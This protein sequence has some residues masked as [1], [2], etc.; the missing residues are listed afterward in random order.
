MRET[1]QLLTVCLGLFSCSIAEHVIATTP[2][3]AEER[4][5]AGHERFLRYC[6]PC[7]GREG[8]GN[9]PVAAS[10]RR[11]PTDLTDVALRRG[12][13]DADFVAQFIDGRIRVEEHGTS[14]MPV[15][16]RRFDDRNAEMAQEALLTRGAISLIVE[17]L[18]SVQV[19]PEPARPDSASDATRQTMDQIFAALAYLLPASVDDERF[20]GL[21]ERD[22]IAAG[23]QLLATSVNALEAHGG[24]RDPGFQ[25]LGG[26]LAEDTREIQ[27]R[28]SQQ[29][30]A[31]AQFFLQQLTE[32]CVA[33]HSRLP[34]QG[35]FAF[36]ESLLKQMDIDRMEAGDH[37]RLLV[38]VRQFEAALQ[39][40]EGLFADTKLSAAEI[41][42]SGYLLDYLTIC[43][44][45]QGDLERPRLAL[46]KFA[47]RPD[48]PRYLGHHLARWI[49]SLRELHAKP[50]QKPTLENARELVRQSQELLAA[51]AN[52]EGLVY[53]LMASSLLHRFVDGRSGPAEE[54]AEAF[55]LL[56]VIQ[57][58]IGY[59]PWVPETE[60]YLE[61]S[62]RLA[63]AT[64]SAER[65]YLLLEEYTVLGYGGSSGTYLP[66]DVVQ[67]LAELRGLLDAP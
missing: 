35:E 22:G 41:D 58:R 63:P 31:E 42:L 43:I 47:A 32:N 14:D 59:A 54:L 10:L 15:W 26:S 5:A 36:A 53:D 57:A 61:A 1:F 25:F 56:G 12:G 40:W 28:F 39:T 18:Q 34:S 13:F 29:R 52:R 4:V 6:A 21:A 44:R 17:Y 45:V 24:E 2:T 9:G 51:A 16:G 55:Y 66:A 50:E 48:V 62:I 19:E 60:Y 65:A 23:L 3:T 37:A 8:F 67:K 30:Y 64:D 20:S 38:S 49:N 7:H 33:C 11:P 27:H 46:E